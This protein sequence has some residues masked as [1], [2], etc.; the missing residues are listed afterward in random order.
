MEG[1]R[2][3]GETRGPITAGLGLVEMR[4]EHHLSAAPDGP[5]NRFRIAPALMADRDAKFQRTRLENLPP[6]TGRID[7]L[8]G[9]VDLFFVLETSHG[10]VWMDDQCGADQRPI[11]N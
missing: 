3:V 8:L 2:R 1:V 9:R 6:G 4:V 10:S 5:A 7:A 11:D